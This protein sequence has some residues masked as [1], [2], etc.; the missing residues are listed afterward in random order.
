[1][2]KDVERTNYD[3]SEDN[4]PGIAWWDKHTHEQT[5]DCQGQDG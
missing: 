2:G 4:V 3:L 1:M 5:Q